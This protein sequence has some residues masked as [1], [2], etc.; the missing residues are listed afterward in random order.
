M[1]SKAREEMYAG[2]VEE[3]ASWGGSSGV[4]GGV[5]LCLKK[6]ASVCGGG[7]TQRSTADRVDRLVVPGFDSDM[8]R[9]VFSLPNGRCD[10]LV[11]CVR[12]R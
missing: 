8:N 2:D 9:A 7:R 5:R 11:G 3:R 12:M 10:E 1:S 6:A 4:R